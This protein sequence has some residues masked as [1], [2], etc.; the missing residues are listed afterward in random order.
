MATHSVRPIPE[1]FHTITPH[2]VIRGAKE[3]IE[4]YKKV[5]GAKETVCM[6]WGGKIGHAELKIGD[7]HLFL[8]DEFP[9]MGSCAP[10][11]GSSSPVVINVYAEDCDAVFNKAVAAGAKVQ[12]PPADMFWG[13]RYCKFADPFGHNWAV[14]THKEDVSP[15]EMA[16][17]SQEAMKEFKDKH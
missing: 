11:P 4:F 9:Q 7:S 6:D 10:A 1:G 2:L 13:D 16:R 15:E 12:M 5:F 17:R 8:A 14:A 3:A